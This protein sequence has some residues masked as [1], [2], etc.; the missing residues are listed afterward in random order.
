M[1]D[2]TLF[3]IGDSVMLFAIIGAVVFAI[4]YAV[5]FNWRLTPAGRSLMYFVLALVGWAVQSFAARMEPDYL[6]RP[7]LRIVV[8]VLITAT[9]WRLVYTLWRSWG[10][11]EFV[12]RKERSED[13]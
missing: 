13:E 2:E 7:Y 10:R 4:S 9:I 8:Y 3:A 6:L 12:A 1:T 5:F 11:F